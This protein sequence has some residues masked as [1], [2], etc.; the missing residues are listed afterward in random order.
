MASWNALCPAGKAAFTFF[1]LGRLR[2]ARPGV[3]VFVAGAPG[4]IKA[5]L[6]LRELAS[7]PC[8]HSGFS[9]YVVW[10]A[11]GGGK[12]GPVMG[13]RP[14]L[15]PPCIPPEAPPWGFPVSAIPRG[16]RGF[17]C[18]S[19]L[20][21]LGDLPPRR[22]MP[23]YGFAL[24]ERSVRRLFGCVGVSGMAAVCWKKARCGEGLWSSMWYFCCVQRSRQ[25]AHLPPILSC[26]QRIKAALFL[27]QGVAVAGGSVIKNRSRHVSEVCV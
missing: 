15:G 6:V 20:A 9:F 1:H 23:T 25:G 18:G 13:L 4:R 2:G 16:L 11:S 5:G 22:A 12:A 7:V 10:A 3:E 27:R 24:G 21:S 17:C 8:G 26:R 19:F 14:L